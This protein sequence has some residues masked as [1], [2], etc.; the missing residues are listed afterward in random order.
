MR[1]LVLYLVC[2]ALAF[3][4]VTPAL[5]SAGT[6]S[7]ADQIAQLQKAVAA[8]KTMTAQQGQQIQALQTQVAAKRTIL[9][10]SG[11]PSGTLGAVGDLYLNTVGYQ[12]YGPKTCLGWGAPV[13]LKG[14][15]GDAGAVGPPGAK[16][17]VGPIGPA[18]PKGDAGP[19]GEDGAIGLQGEKG[20]TGDVGAAGP[21]G[22]KG[23]TGAVGEA[24]PQGV[25]GPTGQDGKDG[26]PGAKGD[27]G[28][29]G[30]IGPPGA[31]GEK[32]DLGPLGPAGPKGDKGDTG[33]V[34]PAGRD[35]SPGAQGE[36]GATGAVGPIGP[37]GPKGDKGEPGP[38][39]RQVDGLEGLF[40]IAPYVGVQTGVMGEAGPSVVFS[41]ANLYAKTDSGVY[42]L[43][44]L[45]HGDARVPPQPPASVDVHVG[46][47]DGAWNVGLSWQR[48][49]GDGIIYVIKRRDMSGPEPG[50][51]VWLFGTEHDYYVDI[52]L[53]SADAAS[54]Q[55][56]VSSYNQYDLQSEMTLSPT[57]I[58]PGV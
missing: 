15:K 58:V 4:L 36:K 56:G 11:A 3:L 30:E 7:T 26:D 39:L 50:P 6:T 24:G 41:G 42:T 23:D 22:P 18:G 31:S 1:R 19:A 55:Y 16:G 28:D 10:G 53:P 5:A 35:G 9:S 52:V 45:P 49:E 37:D 38:D 17:D 40:S 20:A 57:V 8:L 21:P 27:K 25:P 32:G 14:P 34:G 54:Y 46:W 29:P 51:W 33:D 13:S 43:L 44:G 12:L 2:V 47:Q 48:V